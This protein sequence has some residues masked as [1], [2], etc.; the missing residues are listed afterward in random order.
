VGYVRVWRPGSRSCGALI[1]P[2]LAALQPFVPRMPRDAVIA[3][4][5]L[6]RPE[7]PGETLAVDLAQLLAHRPAAR[8]R[9]TARG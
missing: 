8:R 9:D 1:E 4:D 6:N 7:W 2:T 3:F 5:E